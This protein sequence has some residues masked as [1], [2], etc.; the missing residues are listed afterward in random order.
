MSN[1]KGENKRTKEQK[2][3]HR[4]KRLVGVD[5]CACAG[6]H[7]LK[8]Q[9]VCRKIHTDQT[10]KVT[11]IALYQVEIN[12]KPQQKKRD[13]KF[14]RQKELDDNKEAKSHRIQ[15]RERDRLEQ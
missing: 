2:K 11:C 12:P 7:K 5:L 9:G 1:V 13:W 10:G 15:K 3:T 8:C 6:G 4:L 14:G